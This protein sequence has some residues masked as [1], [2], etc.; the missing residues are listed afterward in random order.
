[1][2]DRFFVGGG[3]LL[4]QFAQL[5]HRQEHPAPD[6]IVGDPVS[7]LLA[8]HIDHARHHQH[9]GDIAHEGFQSR[10][11]ADLRKVFCPRK[12]ELSAAENAAALFCKND[13]GG[14]KQQS[15]HDDVGNADAVHAEVQRNGQGGNEEGIRNN[16]KNEFHAG[17]YVDETVF[18]EGDE[19]NGNEAEQD[20]EDIGDRFNADIGCGFLDDVRR[21]RHSRKQWLCEYQ[22]HRRQ[23][24][25]DAER[26]Q[27]SGL[28]AV[29]EF[30]F[31]GND[32]SNKEEQGQDDRLVHDLID[33]I[34]PAELTRDGIRPF[35]GKLTDKKG[36]KRRIDRRAEPQNEQRQV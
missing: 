28:Y 26:D 34:D 7:P 12:R 5:D 29:G 23:R 18:A 33:Q 9:I 27:K 6:E 3:L 15:V 16:A 30:L 32:F 19:R 14:D 35:A 10:D 13:N 25:I 21:R 1:M 20:P 24:R 31:V 2:L 11:A 17:Q 4:D 36:A 22:D 8:H